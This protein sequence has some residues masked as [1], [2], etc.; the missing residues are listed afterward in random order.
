MTVEVKIPV[1]LQEIVNGKNIV[2][3]DSGEIITIIKKISSEYPGF[4]NKLFSKL[5]KIKGYISIL[6][7]GKNIND[8]KGIHT[9]VSNNQKVD[10]IFAVVGG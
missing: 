10:I 9:L 7:D 5:D 4:Y 2:Y 1:P 8:L 3:C 6:V